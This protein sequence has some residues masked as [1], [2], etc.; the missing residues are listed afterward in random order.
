MA[1]RA[2]SNAPMTSGAPLGRAA[3]F[4]V[5]DGK[6]AIASIEGWETLA[7]DEPPATLVPG[8]A[9]DSP[10]PRELAQC[11]RRVIAR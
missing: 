8:G 4:L 2:L 3:A 7:I 6:G 11:R 9:L 5:F 1:L 10:I